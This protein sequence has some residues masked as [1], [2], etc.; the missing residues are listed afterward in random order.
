MIYTSNNQKKSKK[1]K[2]KYIVTEKKEMDGIQT[3]SI[4]SQ[5]IS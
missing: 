2:S 4:P 5:P 1:K 3:N